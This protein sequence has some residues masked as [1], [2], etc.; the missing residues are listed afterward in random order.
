M[1]ATTQ[2]TP[3]PWKVVRLSDLIGVLDANGF[4]VA[5][6]VPPSNRDTSNN[7]ANAAF[8]VT[9]CNA[10]DELVAALRRIESGDFEGSGHAKQIAR[11]ALQ[12]VQA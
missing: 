5:D 6:L 10:H 12:K 4:G 3:T 9:A 7:A 2:H 8:I 11:A 1:T